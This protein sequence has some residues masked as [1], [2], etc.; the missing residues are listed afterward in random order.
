MRSTP[1]L[2]LQTHAHINQTLAI[3]EKPDEQMSIKAFFFFVASYREVKTSREPSACQ[4][5]CER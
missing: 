3:G 5:L 4:D 1:L 2:K